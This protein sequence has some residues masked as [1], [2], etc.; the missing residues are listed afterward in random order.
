LFKKRKYNHGK[1]ILNEKKHL[2][3]GILALYFTLGHVC[4]LGTY[5][6]TYFFFPRSLS[7]SCCFESILLSVDA[8]I[9]TKADMESEVAKAAI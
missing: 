8:V 5:K 9:H 1:E 3:A 2:I 6:H 7:P 4:F